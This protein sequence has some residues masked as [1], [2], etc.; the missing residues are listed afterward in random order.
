MHA[1]EWLARQWVLPLFIA[2]GIVLTFWPEY[3]RYS[4]VSGVDGAA[5]QATLL[6]PKYRAGRF[7]REYWYEYRV[8]GRRHL[9]AYTCDCE[10]LR[11]LKPGETFPVQH[12]IAR[13]EINM[14]AFALSRAAYAGY[15]LIGAAVLTALGLLAAGVQLLRRPPAP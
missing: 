7:E 4:A 5:V 2:L 6:E 9:G 8:E 13:P 14:P 11:L 1:L 15:W 3:R 12:A 10:E